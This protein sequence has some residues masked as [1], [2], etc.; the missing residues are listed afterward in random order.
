M[1]TLENL[2]KIAE[3]RGGG[4]GA[5]HIKKKI[6]SNGKIWSVDEACPVPF[7]HFPHARQVGVPA[8]GTDDHVFSTG[9][10][11]GNVVENRGGCGEVDDE[12]DRAQEIGSECLGARIVGGSEH[13]NLVVVLVRDLGDQ[14]TRFAATEEE[15]VHTQKR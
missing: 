11:R 14:G 5:C 10:D 13:V 15:E 4:G 7:D 9:C 12:V 1:V 8:G 3:G 2:W 6:N